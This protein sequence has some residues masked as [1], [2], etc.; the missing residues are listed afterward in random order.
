MSA[1]C[2]IKTIKTYNGRVCC[3][4]GCKST[5]RKNTE[6]EFYRFPG[7]DYEQTRK[8]KWIISVKRAPNGKERWAPT[9]NT[10]IC[11]LHF[12]GGKKSNDPREEAYNPTIFPWKKVSKTAV[13]RDKRLKNRNKKLES[14]ILPNI[15]VSEGDVIEKQEVQ[16]EMV[17]PEI[18][19]Q[20]IEMKL[21]PSQSPE[22]IL[23][24]VRTRTNVPPLRQ[25]PTKVPIILKS[26]QTTLCLKGKNILSS[27]SRKQNKIPISW[28]TFEILSEND[29]SP[30]TT[31]PR[32]LLI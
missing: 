23:P 2:A 9:K 7:R 29:F 13:E 6:L 30:K 26:K 28:P 4:P 21:E 17:Q 31:F 32:I 1:T 3:V 14:E 22:E 8:I 19:M 18:D 15:N 12:F 27:C 20:D 5:E 11:S 16:S 24:D 10:R 25:K